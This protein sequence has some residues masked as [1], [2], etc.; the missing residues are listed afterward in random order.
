ML[1]NFLVKTLGNK[2]KL[3]ATLP[4]GFFK[5]EFMRENRFVIENFPAFNGNINKLPVAK[6][7][8]CLDGLA[9]KSIKIVYK[10]WGTEWM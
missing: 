3:V 4:K 2:A 10:D 8:D 6:L 9:N 7:R 1:D 5:E